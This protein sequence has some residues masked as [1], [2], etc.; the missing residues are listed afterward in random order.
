MTIRK[1]RGN[2]SISINTRREDV[3]QIQPGSVQCYPLKA[4]RSWT[5]IETH[6][7][8]DGYQDTFSHSESDQTLSQAAWRAYEVSTLGKI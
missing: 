1:F 4:Q 6:K 7:A 8:L 3:T 5:N 2:L